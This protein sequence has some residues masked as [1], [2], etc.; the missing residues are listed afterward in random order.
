MA[1]IYNNYYSMYQRCSRAKRW[2]NRHQCFRFYLTAQGFQT[3]FIS[4]SAVVHEE[5]AVLW[6][7]SPGDDKYWNHFLYW[8][9]PKCGY[10]QFTIWKLMCKDALNWTT[11]HLSFDNNKTV[12]KGIWA[13][14]NSMTQGI[15]IK[16]KEHEWWIFR[17]SIFQW[18]HVKY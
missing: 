10:L 1:H 2:T 5:K 3:L 8:T 13:K 17:Y 16:I 4:S 6:I 11:F 15:N 18:Q 14:M 12:W 7:L 9:I